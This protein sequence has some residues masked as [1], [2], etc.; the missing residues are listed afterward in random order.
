MR[1]A[2]GEALSL[3]GRYKRVFI[4][5][6]CSV[7]VQWTNSQSQP[8]SDYR[9]VA[10]I[11][12]MLQDLK[13][14][15]NVTVS[16]VPAHVGVPGNEDANTAA[17]R[18]AEQV[19]L[20]KRY[21][22]QP[23]VPYGVARAVLRRGIRERWQEQWISTSLFKFD[24]DHLSRIKP[25]V[26]KTPIFFEGSRAEQTT[27]ARL[28][29]GHCGL[30]A[31]ARRWL[32]PGTRV[33]DCGSSEETVRHFL[34]QC[35]IHSKQRKELVCSVN[36]VYDGEVTEELLLGT[37][38]RRIDLAAQKTISSAVHKFVLATKKEL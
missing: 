12:K 26:S 18:G 6:D 37:P 31:S 17:Q 35:P 11:R 38:G 32:A 36:Q 25:G 28:R 16:W 30:V 19:D 27:L 13:Q 9:T 21:H 8:S 20:R 22:H 10:D 2:L 29:F 34:L 15:M 5:C 14:H 1:S 7:A 23:P 4:F 24:H 3:V 33:C